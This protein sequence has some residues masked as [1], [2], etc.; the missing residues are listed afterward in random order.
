MDRE[1]LR[2][3]RW[4]KL[5]QMLGVSANEW[6]NSYTKLLKAWSSPGRYYHSLDHLDAMLGLL[7]RFQHQAHDWPG[8]LLAA[9]YHDAI[10][11]PRASDNEAQSARWFLEEAHSW[12]LAREQCERV[13][14][15][16]RLT[17]THTAHP[18][19]Q[20][21]QLLLDADL[22]ILGTSP[23]E[24]ARYAQAIRQEYAWVPEDAYRRGRTQVLER[25]LQRARIYQTEELYRE[26][27]VAARSNLRKEYASLTGSP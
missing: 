13:V 27:E 11:D 3:A 14:E 19:D 4:Q 15:L 7:E 1:P 5:G 18:E 20:D 12:K 2:L 26:R 8:L 17:Q 24:Y 9:W 21:A 22:A 23:E 6:T 16:I 10:Y 25:F